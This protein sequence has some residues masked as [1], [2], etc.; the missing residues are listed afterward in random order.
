[1]IVT[2]GTLGQTPSPSPGERARLISAEQYKGM[3]GGPRPLGSEK[4]RWDPVPMGG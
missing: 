3:G 4:Y 1:M 2:A